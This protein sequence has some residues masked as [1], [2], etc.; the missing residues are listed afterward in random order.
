M[1][2][3]T[4]GL[5]GL[6]LTFVALA[7]V[8]DTY[9]QSSPA[10][11][12]PTLSA[13]TVISGTV[14]D[15]IS[16]SNVRVGDPVKARVSRAVANAVGEDVIPRDAV[17]HGVISQITDADDGGFVITFHTVEFGG[18]LHSLEARVISLPIREQRRGN[19]AGDA[20]KVGAGAVVGGIAGRILG[21]DSR[22]TILG[23]LGGAAAG[24]GVV[25]A[26]RKSDAVV[27]AGTQVQLQLTAPFSQ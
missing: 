13:G 21:G 22:G 16:A 11:G 7:A 18:R 1:L 15:T 27:D 23:A 5:F 12:A 9:A 19:T 26:T 24:G 2:T 25:A 14:T 17:L 8:G 10:A 6:A 20:A 3:R 4:R